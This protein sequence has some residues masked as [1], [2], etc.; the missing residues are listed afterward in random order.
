[1]EIHAP[2]EMPAI[3][4]ILASRLK[5]CSQSKADAASDNSPAPFSNTPWLRPTPRKLN[6]NTEK[7]RFEN[8]L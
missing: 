2:K 5:D 1:M 7:P 8:M 6:R 3:Q 4:Q